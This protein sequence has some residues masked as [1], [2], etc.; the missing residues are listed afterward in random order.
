[1]VVLGR[2]GALG[3]TVPISSWSARLWISLL[4]QHVA[5]KRYDGGGGGLLSA[6]Y[7]DFKNGVR[8]TTV[9]LAKSPFHIMVKLRGI[10]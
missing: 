4:G 10:A 3:L 7:F 1:M 8:S 9:R 5:D 6:H 2:P